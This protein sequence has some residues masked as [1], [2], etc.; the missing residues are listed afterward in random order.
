MQNYMRLSVSGDIK[1]AIRTYGYKN[2]G[3]RYE[4][5]CKKIRNI[6][7]TKKRHI[8]N[9]LSEHDR[10]KLNSEWDREKNGFL[11]KLFEEEG[12]I[13]KCIPK[14]YTNNPSLNE[15]LSKHIDFCKKKDE[16]LSALQKKSE[17]SACKQYNRWIDAQRTAF[18]LE[19]LKNAK[20]FKSQNVDKYF[21]TFISI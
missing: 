21:I 9:P 6:I 20:T 10:S 1:E 17:Y 5:V 16:R 3:L 4:D 12:F 2:C 8:S 19:Y 13:N 14:K 11:N 15:L 18:T 7:T